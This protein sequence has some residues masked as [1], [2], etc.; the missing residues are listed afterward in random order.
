MLLKTL[1][2]VAL[3]GVFLAVSCIFFIKY[4]F[5][6]KENVVK[7]QRSVWVKNIILFIA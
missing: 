7:N 2:D 5:G 3:T 1:S 4:A 6:I